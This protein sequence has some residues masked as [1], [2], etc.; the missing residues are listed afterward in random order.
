MSILQ[1]EG[2][3][4]KMKHRIICSLILF[5]ILLGILPTFASTNT[6]P[7]TKEDLGVD[8]DIWI[9]PWK[10]KA[11]L[12]T[13]KVDSSEK[14][15]DFA[16]LYFPEEEKNLYAEIQKFIE[17]TNMDMVIVTT[18]E[19]LKSSAQKY[20]DDFYDYNDFGFD[21][22]HSGV[23]FLID[24]D[25]REIWFS[26]TGN[27]ILM[28]N[29]DRINFILDKVMES[30]RVNDYQATKTFINYCGI[31]AREGMPSGNTNY[32]VDAKGRYRRKINALD[33]VVATIFSAVVSAGIT[34]II[35]LKQKEKKKSY[36]AFLYNK[37]FDFTKNKDK[38]VDIRKS[39]INM[40]SS[41]YSSGYSRSSSSSSSYSR[42]SYSS[43]SS[44][45]SSSSGRSH[46][47]G[48]RRF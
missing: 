40:S 41:S 2:R 29:D 13:P 6:Y 12:N 48:G 30:K 1:K 38:L 36:D 10:E 34:T 20:A 35:V 25:T 22:V 39:T 32:Y 7:R 24:M 47:G 26:T 17:E 37:K 27:A 3:Y 8:E 9:T 43:R 28:Y 31:Y 4:E 19:N 21:Q 46:G 42:S 16:N 18:S 15:Y 11:I 14:I 5:W 23:I 45:H 33:Y 44:T